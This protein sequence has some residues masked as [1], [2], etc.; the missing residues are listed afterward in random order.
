MI[1]YFS[2]ILILPSPLL[3]SKHKRICILC[4]RLNLEF[5]IKPNQGPFFHI[6]IL[7]NQFVFP[8]SKKQWPFLCIRFI[9][10]HH[11]S[12]PK[13]TA[14]FHFSQNHHRQLVVVTFGPLLSSI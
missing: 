10:S 5:C 3:N 11:D 13:N 7:R 9:P 1:L 8:R 14:G 6:C 2:W 4:F 12:P